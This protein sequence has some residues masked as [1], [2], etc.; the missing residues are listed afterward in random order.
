MRDYIK[1]PSGIE[2][3][4]MTFR[5]L[6]IFPWTSSIWR[7]FPFKT[8]IATVMFKDKTAAQR[9]HRELVE[10]LKN[11]KV[12]PKMRELFE[13]VEQYAKDNEELVR[14]YRI[15]PGHKVEGKVAVEISEK[16]IPEKRIH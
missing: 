4:V 2:I 16:R 6:L 14:S 7:Q 12:G 1:N 5:P 3:S 11:V 15:Y 13:A 9:G 8:A 10:L